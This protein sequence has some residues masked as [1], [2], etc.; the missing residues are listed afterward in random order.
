MLIYGRMGYVKKLSH[1]MIASESV[2]TLSLVVAQILLLQR[3]ENRTF[4]ETLSSSP[5]KTSRLDNAG[6]K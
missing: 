4:K 5:E 3:M 1:R 2:M 6:K